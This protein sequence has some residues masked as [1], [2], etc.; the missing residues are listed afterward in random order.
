MHWPTT[1]LSE[2]ISDARILA[3]GYDADVVN[4]WNPASG[5]TIR[6]HAENMLGCLARQREETNSVRNTVLSLLGSGAHPKW[7]YAL[8]KTG[9]LYS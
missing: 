3:F 6:N 9:K 5:N 1:L 2:D 7:F 4:F 8:R